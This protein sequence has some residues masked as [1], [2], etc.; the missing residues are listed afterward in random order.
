MARLE[1][2]GHNSSRVRKEKKLWQQ[3][4]KLNASTRLIVTKHMNASKTSAGTAGSTLKTM[5]S[6]TSKTEPTNITL[7]KAER[8]QRS[9]WLLGQATNI[10]KPKT[11]ASNRTTCSRFQNAL[12]LCLNEK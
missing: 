5:R 12:D 7:T 8:R 10:S 11:T 2:P 4:N 9:L 1:R 6:R 3:E